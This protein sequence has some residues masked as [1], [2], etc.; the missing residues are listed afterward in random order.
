MAEEKIKS[1]TPENDRGGAFDITTID[2]DS[3][4]ELLQGMYLD[5]ETYLREIVRIDKQKSA[6][7]VG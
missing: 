3:L 6:S 1:G 2:A 4:D 5:D 7:S